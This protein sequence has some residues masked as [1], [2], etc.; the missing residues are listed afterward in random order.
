DLSLQEALS[1]A[2][3][4]TPEAK[5]RAQLETP[6][7]A[8]ALLRGQQSEPRLVNR[9][10]LNTLYRGDEAG[11]L[12]DVLELMRGFGG[13]S[14]FFVRGHRCPVLYVSQDLGS[15]NKPVLGFLST[16][17][18]ESE[19]D[20][21]EDGP[22][23][24]AGQSTFDTSTIQLRIDKGLTGEQLCQPLR[25][26]RRWTVKELKR[27]ISHHAGIAEHE[28]RLLDLAS[29]GATLGDDQMLEDILDLASAE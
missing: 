20:L 15:L 17:Q 7:L 8:A 11:R 27:A 13:T 9:A 2:L 18:D 29:G 25:V 22:A 16:W 1:E 4:L 3:G 14:R 28:Q 19:Q 23:H 6:S 26:G 5:A 10:F 21:A 24:L 12:R